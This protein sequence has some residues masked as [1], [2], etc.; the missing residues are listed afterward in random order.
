MHCKFLSLGVYS[1]WR[2]DGD[3]NTPPLSLPN[4]IRKAPMALYKYKLQHLGMLYNTT[5]TALGYASQNYPSSMHNLY[6]EQTTHD[7]VQMRL[8]LNCLGAL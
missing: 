8:P 4:S 1:L 5:T 3:S 2:N 7:A 6:D